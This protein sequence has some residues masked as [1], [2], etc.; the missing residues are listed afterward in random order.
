[1]VWVF[2][3]FTTDVSTRRVSPELHFGVFGVCMESVGRGGPLL[4]T[5]LYPPE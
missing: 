3:L 4:Q 2:S 5:V 1:M